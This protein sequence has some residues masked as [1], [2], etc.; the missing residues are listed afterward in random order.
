MPC[1]AV[2]TDS[3]GKTRDEVDDLVTH[4]E[5]RRSH[6]VRAEE[7]LQHAREEQ[8]RASACKV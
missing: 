6:I 3:L 4:A 8:V 7:K 1:L 2:Q 5:A